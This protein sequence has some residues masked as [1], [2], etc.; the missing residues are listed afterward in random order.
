MKAKKC[1]DGWGRSGGFVCKVVPSCAKDE[2]QESEKTRAGRY[3]ELEVCSRLDGTKK[4]K[5]I[6][7]TEEGEEMEVITITSCL[8]S[9]TRE[10]E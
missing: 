4:R 6:E 3:K 10:S 8:I 9:K 2:S 5:T 1:N 7:K